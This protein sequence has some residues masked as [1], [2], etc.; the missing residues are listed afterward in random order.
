MK[1]RL[2]TGRLSSIEGALPGSGITPEPLR[3]VDVSELRLDAGSGTPVVSSARKFV[4]PVHLGD[5]AEPLV[6]PKD[7]TD[8]AGDTK[9]AGDP[10]C[11]W[12]GNPKEGK[13]IVFWNAKDNCY[14]AAAQS[15]DDASRGVII[16]NLVEESQAAV[17][18]ER[19]GDP[20]DLSLNGLRGV[21]ETAVA[22]GLSDMYDSDVSFIR[23]KMTPA[24]QGEQPLDCDQNII[25]DFGYMKRDDRD[26]CYAAWVDGPV[27]VEGSATATAQ[28][29]PDGIVLVTQGQGDKASTR[30]VQPDAFIASYR[31][32]DGRIVESP[33]AELKALGEGEATP[34]Q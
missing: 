33:A 13:G 7:F 5:S 20:R 3:V 2:E 26:V 14:Q 10:I 29:G 4:I 8:S 17:L 31:H 9:K 30:G 11:D 21:L 6:Y 1:E 28:Q 25:P 27:E 22:L 19:T 16:I 34:V 32:A 15:E 23:K 24:V 18:Y 12:E